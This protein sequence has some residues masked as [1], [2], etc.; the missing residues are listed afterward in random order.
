[1]HLRWNR[2]AELR[3]WQLAGVVCFRADRAREVAN[4]VQQSSGYQGIIGAFLLGKMRGLQHV[5]RLGDRLA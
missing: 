2:S 5:R 4:I 1:V 3:S